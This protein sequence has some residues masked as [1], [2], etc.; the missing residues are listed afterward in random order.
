MDLGEVFGF[1]HSQQIFEVL[2]LQINLSYLQRTSSSLEGVLN[3]R[4]LEGCFNLRV[5][6]QLGVGHVLSRLV[7]TVKLEQVF[8][9]EV[10]HEVF[11]KVRVDVMSLNRLPLTI[12]FASL[13][14]LAGS[15][16][17]V[18]EDLVGR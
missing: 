7:P 12:Y 5:W 4:V 10:L 14:S 8:F 9:L 17:V 16:L 13:Q 3:H 18:F 15:E 2:S 11:H 6:G 1:A